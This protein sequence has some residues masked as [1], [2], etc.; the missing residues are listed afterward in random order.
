M[1]VPRRM[2]AQEA[3]RSARVGSRPDTLALAS[4][5]RAPICSISSE[6]AKK[7]TATAMKLT[8][9]TTLSS[10]KVKRCAPEL[11][12]VPT[13]LSNSPSTIMV[14]DFMKSPVCSAAVATRASTTR[15]V[16]SG[17]PNCSAAEARGGEN[18]AMMMTQMQPATKE[19]IAEMQSAGP[20]APVAR[21]RVPVEADHHGGRL[22]RH[23]QHDGGGRAGVVGAVIDTRQHDQRGHGRDL[24]GHRQ[25]DRDGGHRPQAGEHP[26]QRAERGAREAIGEVLRCQRDPEASP[27]RAEQV[28]HEGSR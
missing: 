25:Q 8:P 20:G 19:L 6:T 23:V 1:A 14:T 15:A 3:A 28:R 18:S 22:A 21:H 4:G 11:M 26:H 12:S 2:G 16:Y 10:P 17:A 9:S 5:I 24:E 13:V 7:P 27:Q